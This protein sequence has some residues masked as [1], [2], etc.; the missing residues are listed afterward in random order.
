MNGPP[1]LEAPGPGA[2]ERGSWLQPLL[3]SCEL[4]H[5][6]HRASAWCEAMG[7]VEAS[8]VMGHWRDLA[9][10]LQLSEGE[11]R[12]LEE[13]CEAEAEDWSW[14]GTWLESI[15]LGHYAGEALRWCRQMGAA[16]LEEVMDCWEVFA[17][18]LQ[19]DPL[20]I[21]R[22]AAAS[23]PES[24]KVRALPAESGAAKP[25]G[26]LACSAH[27]HPRSCGSQS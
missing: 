7:A 12:R 6:Y 5:E 9:D 10:Q 22:L 25:V 18:D 23:G 3:A 14:L 13:V 19:M 27:E 2:G 4:L 15:Q 17:A 20:E 26:V 24:H 16:S 8:E 21:R 11:R 1:Q